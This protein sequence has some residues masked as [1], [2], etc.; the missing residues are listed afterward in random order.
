MIHILLQFSMV[1]LAGLGLQG[2]LNMVS[3]KNTA[4]LKHLKRYLLIFG[5]IVLLLLF[6]LL[7]GKSGYLGWASKLRQNADAAY[8]KAL[9]DGFRALL[10]FLLSAGAVLLTLKKKIK[11][12]WL[13]FICIVLMLFDVWPVSK[14]F[15][16][17][18]PKSDER[19]F[20][21]E[22]EE[23]KYLKNLEKPFRIVQILD[24]RPPNWYAYHKIQNVWGYQGAKLKIYQEFMDALR[25]PNGPNGF[26]GLLQN[27]IKLENEQHVFKNP[28]EIIPHQLIPSHNFMKL[29]NTKYILSPYPIPDPSFQPLFPPKRRGSNGIYLYKDALPRIFFPETVIRVKGKETI[30]DYITSPDFNPEKTAVLE[31][32]PLFEIIPSDSNT[33]K[34]VK[35]DIHE[36]EITA[37][38]K[39]PAL[40]VLSEIYYPAGWKAYIDNKKVKIWKTNYILRSIFIEPGNHNVK[41]IF[42]PKAF[43]T[44]L[45][46]SITAIILLISGSVFGGLQEKR[47]KKKQ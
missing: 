29:L 19:F 24:Q 14:R 1:V 40:M 27:Y 38:I 37:D 28:D 20:F 5:A 11:S 10:F 43:H 9:Q 26:N 31:E 47:R 46:V 32:M 44:G 45:I 6:L 3:E 8:D 4:L 23:I 34:I 39:K 41:F 30:L 21:T 15:V 12:H 22:T 18:K 7:V 16:D 2:I 36:I 42:K 13:P 33:V 25:M 17:P 35:Y